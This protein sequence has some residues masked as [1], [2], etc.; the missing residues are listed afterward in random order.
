MERLINNRLYRW[1]E[2]SNILP[3]SQF[4][5]RCGRSCLDNL[6]ILTSDI[7][8]NWYKN[9]NTCAIFLDIKGA[10]DSVLSDILVK[11]LQRLQIPAPFIQFV[12]NLVSC[13]E[14]YYRFNEINCVRTAHKG[15]PQGCVL[16]PL[17]YSLYVLNLEE[18]VYQQ[19]GIKILQFADDVCL[20][21]SNKSNIRAARD[22]E[23]SIKSTTEWFDNLGLKL[24]PHKSQVCLFSRK[25][26]RND[27]VR[28]INMCGI[29]VEMVSKV[30]FLGLVLQ[31]NLKWNSHVEK[32]CEKCTKATQLIK[33]LRTTW[34]G[35]GPPLL[36][37]IYIKA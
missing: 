29:R 30:N 27:P 25:Y 33:F 26:N 12:Y 21:T 23:L 8:A 7:Q 20:Y 24:A 37:N 13:R 15:L 5:F 17:L 34:W 2:W 31:D 35:S 6:A 18:S 36:L 11:Q 9:R 4:G 14:V 16:S 19:Q 10:Y 1:L 28:Y 3:N 32:V 22:I